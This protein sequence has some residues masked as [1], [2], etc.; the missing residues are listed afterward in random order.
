MHV[1]EQRAFKHLHRVLNGTVRSTAKNDLR[2]YFFSFLPPSCQVQGCR[3]LVCF[4]ALTFSPPA[5]QCIQTN[6]LRDLDVHLQMLLPCRHDLANPRQEKTHVLAGTSEVNPCGP[7][8]LFLCYCLIQECF[9]LLQYGTEAQN[10]RAI[11]PTS[12]FLAASARTFT[13]GRSSQH[14]LQ[15]APNDCRPC[16]AAEEFHKPRHLQVLV[17]CASCQQLGLSGFV[18]LVVATEFRQMPLLVNVIP[19]VWAIRFLIF[20]PKLI[21]QNH[22]FHVCRSHAGPVHCKQMFPILSATFPVHVMFL[23]HQQIRRLG[24]GREMKQPWLPGCIAC[25]QN[26]R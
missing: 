23:I 17:L 18:L 14:C 12:C 22:I 21:H 9:V 1:F 25:V 6:G 4:S 8:L 3:L 16:D 13:S 20:P 5:L 7:S 19:T 10:V 2:S 11:L 15:D 24:A 26:R